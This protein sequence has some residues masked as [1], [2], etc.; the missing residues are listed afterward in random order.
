MEGKEPGIFGKLASTAL[1]AGTLT[2]AR[3]KYKTKS[4]ELRKKTSRY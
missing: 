3:D 2:E 4:D 1:V